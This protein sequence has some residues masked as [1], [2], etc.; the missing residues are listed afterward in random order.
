MLSYNELVD[1]T[2]ER[3]RK[4]LDVGI[5]HFTRYGFRKAAIGDICRDAGISKPTF[6]KYFDKKETLFFAVLIYQGKDFIKIIQERST[7]LDKASQKLAVFLE[8]FEEFTQSNPLLLE[9][10]RSNPDLRNSFSTSPLGTDSYMFT[11]DFVERIILEGIASGEFR[12]KEPRR[13]AHVVVLAT[14]L[15]YI[16]EAETPRISS[17]N[18]PAAAFLV[19][20]LTNGIIKPSQ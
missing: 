12:V 18:E 3:V 17:A 11:V 15:F 5:E 1:P 4:I 6:Y 14:S 7:G 16:F 9:M 19:D 13:T 2:D 10:W 20:L 8:T